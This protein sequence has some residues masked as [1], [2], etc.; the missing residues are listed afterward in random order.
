MPDPKPLVLDIDGTFIKSDMLFEAFWAGL[1]KDPIAVIKLS[2]RH[3]T[4]PAVLKSKLAQ[5]AEIRTDLL[6]LQPQVSALADEALAEGREVVLAS[7]SDLSQVSRLAQDHGLSE[8]VFASDGVV[9][10]K[11]E[12]KR[13]ALVDAFGEGGFDYAGN[14][15]TDMPIWKAS[16][17]AI[18]VGDK[19]SVAHL[20]DLD[21]DVQEITIEQNPRDWLR[22]M[23]PHQYVKN[24]LLFLPMLAAHDFSFGSIWL[25]LL[26]LV[27]FSA[28][29]SCIYIVND[30]LDLEADRLHETKCNRPFASGAVSIKSGMLLCVALGAF[31]VGLASIL[32]TEF[33]A[34]IAIYMTLSLAYSLKLKR[35][36]WVDIAVLATL[37]ALRVIAVR[38]QAVLRHRFTC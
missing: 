29:A 25:T 23:R 26:G 28:A 11:G 27:A 34:V 37:Y 8:R 33:L 13:D 2:A 17:R 10:L 3:F 14:E 38:R 16:D 7:A 36:R 35:M 6:P 1:G 24:V 19:A 32:S 18:V 9:N 30:L 4:R 12:A 15:P 5:V 22:A 31:A 20:R 21:H